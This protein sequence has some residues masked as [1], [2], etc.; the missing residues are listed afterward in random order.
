MKKGLSSLT[1]WQAS[2]AGSPRLIL[3]GYAGGDKPARHCRDIKGP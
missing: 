3:A 2:G 1:S